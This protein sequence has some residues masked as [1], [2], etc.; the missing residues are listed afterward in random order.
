V[1]A[2]PCGPVPRKPPTASKRRDRPAVFDRP[3]WFDRARSLAE[4]HGWGR[5]D[6][7]DGRGLIGR[8]T[9][10]VQRPVGTLG[11]QDIVMLLGQGT[12]PHFLVPVALDLAPA[13]DAALL[14][15]LLALDPAFWRS[16]PHLRGVLAGLA[17]TRT[18]LDDE[19]AAA[20]AAFAARAD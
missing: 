4:L 7:G 11:A 12:D 19:L 3:Y 15:C 1:I 16:H 10:A 20:L 9:A 2:V 6:P 5:A 13:G 17:A 18:N 8:Y 14:R